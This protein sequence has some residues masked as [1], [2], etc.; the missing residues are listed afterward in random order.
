MSVHSSVG[1]APTVRFGSE[2]QKRHFLSKLASGEWIG[3]FVLTAP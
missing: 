2:Q 1:C 3:G